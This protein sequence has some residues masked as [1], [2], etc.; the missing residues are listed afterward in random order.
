MKF[1]L[2]LV[3]KNIF[4]CD[5]CQKFIIIRKKKSKPHHVDITLD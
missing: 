5:I 4:D 2:I 3:E 1:I